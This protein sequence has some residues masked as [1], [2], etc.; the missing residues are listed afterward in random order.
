MRELTIAAKTENL[1]QVLSF[2]DE[3]LE[4]LGCTPR[5]QIQIEVAVEEIF[6]NV[7]QYAFSMEKMGH[8]EEDVVTIGVADS[9][10]PLSVTVSF[11]DNGIPFDPLAREDP[12]TTLSSEAR[13]IGGLGIFMVKKGM[14]DVRYEFKN[15]KN[16]LTFRK[17]L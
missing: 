5:A 11:M 7:A 14:D 8:P 3:E 13:K 6:V 1:G 9:E 15:G 2:V 10:D 4:R 16:I 12:D 17:D